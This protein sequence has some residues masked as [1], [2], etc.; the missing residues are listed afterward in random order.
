MKSLLTL[1]CLSILPSVV[2][3]QPTVR[4]YGHVT[5][6]DS[7]SI[8]GAHVRMMNNAFNPVAETVSDDS[9]RYELR[10]PPGRYMA[11]VVIRD[12]DYRS[13]RLEYWAWNVLAREDLEINPRYHRME[14]YAMNAFRPQGG[15]P[16]YMVYFR[17]M[18]LSMV[19]AGVAEDSTFLTGPRL[20][21]A[22]DFSA[23]DIEVTI[24][25]ERVRILAITR[26]EESGGTSTLF[27]YLIQCDLPKQ[28]RSGSIDRI[29]ITATDP[30]SK[31]KGEGVLFLERPW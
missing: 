20:N 2:F 26:V 24:N 18:S 29:R 28:K 3:S 23:N 30:V 4:V 31:D 21:I 11:L 5:D 16:S 15:Y 9:G 7:R 1:I 10:V 17:P 22:P 19:E 6:F 8:G 14:I 27:G 25:G 13:S 12:S